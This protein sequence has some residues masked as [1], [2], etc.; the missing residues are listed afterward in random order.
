MGERDPIV[1]VNLMPVEGVVDCWTVEAIDSDGGVH[2]AD[3]SGKYAEE[4]A[5]IWAGAAYPETGFN[6]LPPPRR[7]GA[8]RTKARLTIV[9]GTAVL[10]NQ[11]QG[12]GNG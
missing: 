4:D 1:E 12:E 9:G 2:K 11:P 7:L 5:R 3:F 6:I 10:P 8:G